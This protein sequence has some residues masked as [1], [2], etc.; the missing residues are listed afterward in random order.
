M[1]RRKVLGILAPRPARNHGA[2]LRGNNRLRAGSHLKFAL[3][4]RK[5]FS[6]AGVAAPDRRDGGLNG[7]CLL[8][9]TQIL[10]ASR[11]AG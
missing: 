11:V 9:G 2:E 3:R 1:T 7:R 5:R 10:K 4:S 8:F 6:L